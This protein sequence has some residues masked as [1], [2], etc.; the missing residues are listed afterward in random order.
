[1]EKRTL[2]KV[3]IANRGEIA[4]RIIRS[5][6]ELGIR[7]VA[8]YSEAD[9][10]APHVQLADEA[11]LLGPPPSR[12][13]YLAI[14]RVLAAARQS[15]ADAIHPGYGFLSENAQFARRVIEEKLLFV[16]PSPAAIAAMGD[17]LEARRLVK[18]ANVPTVPGTEDPVESLEDAKAFCSTSGFPVL[19]KAAA[20]GGGKGMRIVH[21]RNSLASAFRAAQSE[22]LSAFGDSRVYIEKYLENP[23]HI[24]F[25]ILGDHFGNIIHLGERECSIQ[26]RHQKVIEETPSVIV[27]DALRAR[28][29]DTAVAAARSC[30]YANAGTVEF[31]VDKEKKFYFLE[32]NTRLQ[33]E[34][35]ITE[36]RTGIDIVAQQLRIARG[37]PLAWAQREVQFRGHAIEC[38]IY[39][40]DAENDFL[41]STGSIVHLKPSQG[42]GVRD[43]RGVEEGGVISV[44]YD[45]LI[46]KLCVWGRTRPEAIERMKRALY[47]YEILGVRTNIS[48]NL[49]VLK[50]P[51]FIEGKF[52][53][54]FL[55]TYFKTEY[56]TKPSE[57]EASAAAVAIALYH[58]ENLKVGPL[59]G[60]PGDGLGSI[61]SAESVQ[62]SNGRPGEVSWKRQRVDNMR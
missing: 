51:V 43:D 11:Y 14:D 1:M 18:R 27:D 25:Q 57:Q 33:V 8:V 44:Y 22:A 40:E 17:K 45:P 28:M 5:C 42:P 15:G 58:H 36:L 59:A 52:D 3:L 4:V 30:G 55:S 12:E 9:R 49:F 53:T 46:A 39:A 54:H 7:T 16:G 37:E 56:L 34:H 13:S 19:I 62:T 21:D 61:K 23:R 29:G 6:K 60:L 24:E 31:L 48:L 47:E 50:H 2:T 32:M 35:P 38:R 26:R 20:G 41:P 10:N